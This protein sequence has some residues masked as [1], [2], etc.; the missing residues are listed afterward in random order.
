MGYLFRACVAVFFYHGDPIT[1][2]KMGFQRGQAAARRAAFRL[3]LFGTVHKRLERY[4][5]FYHKIYQLPMSAITS[6]M[7]IIAPAMI[8]NP[9][10]L[11]II[12]YCGRLAHKNVLGPDRL[13]RV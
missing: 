4:Q 13:L 10:S 5:R 9:G 7:A 12:S 11:F 3:F 6:D 2:V 8:R 1:N